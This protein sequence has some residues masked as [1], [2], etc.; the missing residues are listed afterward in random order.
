MAK[1]KT[2]K[3]EA[4]SAE[5][6]YNLGLRYAEG[7][8]VPLDEVEAVRVFTLAA[9]QGMPEAQYKLGCMYRD[10]LTD[11]PQDYAKAA[12]FFHAA[13]IQNHADAQNCL[14]AC[15]QLGNGVQKNIDE[16]LKWYRLAA[17][18]GNSKAQFNLGWCY[19]KGL[20][21]PE[22]HAIA[23]SWYEKSAEQ[24]Y[25]RA[26]D[27]VM[28]LNEKDQKK[29]LEEAREDFKRQ[30]HSLSDM[31]QD[32]NAEAQFKLGLLLLNGPGAY[33]NDAIIW[34]FQAAENGIVQA[35]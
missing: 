27:A 30:L 32:G 16:A 2:T 34:F 8:D 31:A 23:R 33:R 14:G 15:Y 18:S 25:D 19:A 12:E 1:K 22:D 10:G 35:Q 24:G 29:A 11:I 28:E 4:V 3:E 21:V 5:A 17:E 20:G 26:L 13:A 9:E 6:Q 7:T